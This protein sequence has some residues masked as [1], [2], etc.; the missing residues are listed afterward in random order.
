MQSKG[1]YGLDK[2]TWDYPKLNQW[3]IAFSITA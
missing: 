2:E 1:R 3:E